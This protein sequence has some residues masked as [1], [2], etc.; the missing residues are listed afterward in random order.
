M[1]WGLCSPF[2]I[3]GTVESYC[4]ALFLVEENG[5]M[6]RTPSDVGEFSVKVP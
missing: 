6:S 3:I 4:H 5:K 2:F 1:K